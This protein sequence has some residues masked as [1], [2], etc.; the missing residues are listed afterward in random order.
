MFSSKIFLLLSLLFTQMVF[1]QKDSS[2]SAQWTSLT[3]RSLPIYYDHQNWRELTVQ[4]QAGLNYRFS[5]AQT[6]FQEVQV[7]LAYTHPLKLVPD[8]DLFGFQDLT[9]VLVYAFNP[10]LQVFAGSLLP[11][12]RS[13]IKKPLTAAG[14]AGV[15]YFFSFPEEL[16]EVLRL[17]LHFRHFISLNA[18]H[19]VLRSFLE[20]YIH[21][22]FIVLNHEFHI[23]GPSYAG[24]S[25]ESSAGFQNFYTHSHKLYNTWS[26]EMRLLYSWK[27]LQLFASFARK[28]SYYDR[29]V[30]RTRHIQPYL[31]L[32]GAVLKWK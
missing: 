5:K 23:K 1:A 21:N 29:I 28:W 2:W 25:L 32:T 31:F 19:N 14:S 9:A 8:P 24:F 11:L 22:D 18:H 16:G 27:Y 4:H 20:S 17:T 6:G 30:L 3:L 26:A 13:S 12:S 10:F 15:S 7:Q